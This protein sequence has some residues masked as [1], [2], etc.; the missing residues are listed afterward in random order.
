MSLENEARDSSNKSSHIANVNRDGFW[1]EVL[2]R[3]R[4]GHGHRQ[5]GRGGAAREGRQVRHCRHQLEGK[6]ATAFVENELV[7]TSLKVSVSVRQAGEET[8]K[9]L[10]RRHGKN[11]VAYRRIDVS[12]ANN[13]QEAFDFCVDTFGGVDVVVN[14]AGV[15]GESNW[16]SM[17]DINLKV[18]GLTHRLYFSNSTVRNNLFHAQRE[19]SPGPTPASVTWAG[20]ER[21]TP[22]RR[23]ETAASS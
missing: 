6:H 10:G 8:A 15:N 20:T 18:S 22:V 5:G 21:A 2:H 12:S 14:N 3:D 23:Q 1:R 16:E 4:V 9:D 19:S 13:V 7:N 11:N 17:L